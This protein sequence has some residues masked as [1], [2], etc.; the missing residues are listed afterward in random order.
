M[1]YTQKTQTSRFLRRLKLDLSESERAVLL[2]A[3]VGPN[4][5][6]G[7]G[8]SGR[9]VSFESEGG[10][11]RAKRSKDRDRGDDENGSG[12]DGNGVRILFRD[13]LELVLAEKVKLS[14]EPLREGVP[15]ALAS[16]FE[17]SYIVSFKKH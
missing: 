8:N 1:Q 16:C 7:G 4:D 6:N 5:G 11:R 14:S 2:D 15:K 13:F 17:T 12:E 10:S 3:L 9:G